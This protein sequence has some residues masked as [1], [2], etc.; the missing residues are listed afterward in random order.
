MI[1]IE[2]FMVGGQ[3]GVKK[4]LDRLVIDIGSQ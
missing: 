4:D 3:I 1:F 2:E